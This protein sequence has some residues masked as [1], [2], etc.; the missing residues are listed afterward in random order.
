[1]YLEAKTQIILPKNVVIHDYDASYFPN[2]S[3]LMPNK[4]YPNENNLILINWEFVHYHEKK[5]KQSQSPTNETDGKDLDTN[6]RQKPGNDLANDQ[7]INSDPYL[8]HAEGDSQSITRPR[9]RA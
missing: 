6:Q 1:M 9:F 7:V 3:N 8:D 2:S 5:K 4:T